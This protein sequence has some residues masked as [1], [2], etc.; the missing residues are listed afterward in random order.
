MKLI[1]YI[2]GA[3][4]ICLCI[5]AIIGKENYTQGTYMFLTILVLSFIL[6]FYF[7]ED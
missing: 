4:Y 1:K 2:A 7:L 6:R 3:F 5:A